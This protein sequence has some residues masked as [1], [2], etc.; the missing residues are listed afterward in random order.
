MMSPLNFSKTWT[1][2]LAGLLL[3]FCAV[4][5]LPVRAGAS[6]LDIF[7]PGVNVE[8]NV[9]FIFDT[10]GSM[11]DD[12]VSSPYDPNT[13]YTCAS[14]TY[15]ANSVY[16]QDR[17][18]I[19]WLNSYTKI[20]NDVNSNPLSCTSSTP[21]A[22]GQAL[23]Q[24]QGFWFPNST[25]RDYTGN[26][27]N[28]KLSPSSAMQQ[29]IVIAKQVLTDLIDAITGVRM[30]LMVFNNSEGGH[31]VSA[32]ADMTAAGKTSLK[33]SV[34]SASAGGWTPLGET[35]YE[36]GLYFSGAASYYNSGTYTSP[37]QAACQ[38]N[39]VIFMT[40]GSP[41]QD[42]NVPNPPIGDQDG[43]GRE[44]GGANVPAYSNSGSDYMD[45]VAMYWRNHDMVSDASMPGVQFMK[46]YTV[47]FT[48]SS[49]PLANPLLQRT[50]AHGDGQFFGA[51]NTA[52]LK[53]ALTATLVAISE[54]TNSFIAPVVPIDEAN[55]TTSGDFVYLSLF[56]PSG[57][58]LW[59]GNLKKFGLADDGHLIDRNGNAA[60]DSSGQLLDTADS[61]WNPSGTPDGGNVRNG[62]VEAVLDARST[63]R[64]LYTKVAVSNNL[65]DSG[66][67]FAT[68][69]A[70][71]TQAMLGVGSAA[72]RTQLIDFVRGIDTYDD[73]GN[74]NTTE[75]RDTQL[76]DLLHSRPVV[77]HYDDSNTVIYLGSND[78]ILHAFNDSD[79]SERWGFVPADVLGSLQYLRGTVHTPMLDAPVQ[80]YV[81]DANGDHQIRSADGDKAILI[82][83]RRRG[84]RVYTALDV[85][86]PDAPVLLYSISNT[87]SGFSELGQT[88]SKPAIGKVKVSGTDTVVAIVSA[89]YDLNEDNAP[90]SVADTM[91]RGVF[92][93]NVLTGAKVWDFTYNAADTTKVQMV[94]AIASDVSPIDAN[95]DGFL[96]RIYVGDLGGILWRF[97]GS[98]YS[99]EITTWAGSLVFK[100]KATAGDTDRRKFFNPPDVVQESTFDVVLTGTGDREHPLATTPIDRFYSIRDDNPGSPYIETNL[101][102]LTDDLLQTGTSAQKTSVMNA[103]ATS[104][105][106]YIRLVTNPSDT[107]GLGEKILSAPI[108][109]SK[110]VAFTS[111]IP[112]NSL[113]ACSTGGVAR[114]YALDFLNGISVINFDQSNDSGGTTVM[115]RSDR[116]RQVGVS[117]A[118][119][120]VI[121]LRKG[122]AVAYVGTGGGVAIQDLSAPPSNVMLIQWQ[123]LQ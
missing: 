6:D 75:K 68:S 32:V 114:L 34:N 92:A 118:S 28:Y 116:F 108:T 20:C 19:F 2:F 27:L 57:N 64:N 69:N 77:I 58:A 109:F 47:G 95:A 117:I 23:L 84:G 21:T 13:T 82:F 86:D 26:Y 1:L 87:T 113:V 97:G 78:G 11:G 107:T 85:T 50:A 90:L 100:A 79:G 35:L 22:A 111:F 9:L 55:R 38:K 41:T 121:A 40:D 42:L 36:A 49:D 8:P 44:P 31:I 16:K 43:D 62:G 119:S 4:A 106:Y 89:G 72:A 83:G 29:K 71:I 30:G 104:K 10:S 80:S 46:T 96:D 70:S 101:V 76:G 93:F 110:V 88:W 105:G 81:L 120:A 45:D 60:L 52:Q 61:Y 98:S 7:N 33:S 12:I 122:K 59:Q 63:A 67:V 37:I 66:N 24:S 3:A 17:F 14:C 53:E 112:N 103:L 99:S 48:T 91:G 51:D 94:N 54:D 115:A 102:D 5:G 73:D 15:T 65:T 25:T 18:F 39:Y 56:A 74:S 123:Q